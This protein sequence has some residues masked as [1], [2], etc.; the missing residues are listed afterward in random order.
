MSEDNYHIIRRQVVSLQLPPGSD[1]FAWQQRVSHVCRER[2]QPRLEELLSRF[3]RPDE[4][5]QLDRVELDLGIINVEGMEEALTEKVI[6]ALEQRLY[7]ILRLEREPAVRFPQRRR[8]FEQWLE[9]LG[10]GALPW[11][12]TTQP[13][14]ALL[15]AVLEELSSEQPSAT[16]LRELL[17]RNRQAFLRLIRQYPNGFL[18]TLAEAASGEKQDALLPLLERILLF[19]Q[20]WTKE[21]SFRFPVR[22]PITG[23]LIRE[24]FWLFTFEK[25]ILQRMPV[26]RPELHQSM[27]RRLLPREYRR[28]VLQAFRAWKKPPEL[29]GE[30]ERALAALKPDAAAEPDEG[31][32]RMGGAEEGAEE[33]VRPGEKGE[34]GE[35]TGE[36][37]NQDKPDGQAP[38]GPKEQGRG[39][40]PKEQELPSAR[41]GEEPP[42]E[43]AVSRPEKAEER[44]G[45]MEQ[46]KRTI[47]GKMASFYDGKGQEGQTEEPPPDDSR[48]AHEKK[49]ED[50]VHARDIDT[51]GPEVLK[52]SD[53]DAPAVGQEEE[54]APELTAPATVG[55]P[56]SELPEGQSYYIRN[57]GIVLLHPFLPAFFRKLELVKEADFIDEA[58][59]Q[60]AI[61]LI[62]FL[63]TGEEGLPE[64]ELVLPKFLC[65]LPLDV[66]INRFQELSGEEK[67]ES[68]KLLKAAIDHWGALGS[69]SPAG[70]QEGFL[71]REGKLEK[72]RQGWYLSV[73]QKTIDILLDR[74]PF[75]WGLGMVKLPWMEEILR[76]EWN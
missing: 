60:R 59:R 32:R 58:A 46:D 63:A 56:Y 54:K 72:R 76:V 6:R 41:P 50:T 37:Q 75:G 38:G 65:A 45:V 1:G 5:I 31:L 52:E 74:L 29:A 64:Y 28:P 67:A 11:H 42:A 47:P 17:K 13:E 39:V 26:L 3:S 36:I 18:A 35:E 8:V 23:P 53:E 69:T 20:A 71:Q 21:F 12:S 55:T 24:Y 7:A 27:I 10:T 48:R 19:W 49:R 30:I 68:Q 9:Y 51:S 22:Q 43:E 61:H 57:A 33:S 66:P 70:L 34:R 40:V 16:A 62:Q 15:K 2:L 73:E 14:A 4:L 44:D 25:L